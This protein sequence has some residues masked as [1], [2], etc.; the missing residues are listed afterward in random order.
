MNT[1]RHWKTEEDQILLKLIENQESGSTWQQLADKLKEKGITKTWDQCKRRYLNH[2]A[3]D[4]D[5]RKFNKEEQ[6]KLL[7]LYKYHGRSWSLISTFFEKRTDNL[8]K[9]SFFGIIRRCLRF[10]NKASNSNLD[11]SVVNACRPRIMFDFLE[12]TIDT[13]KNGSI[14]VFEV[15]E[16]FNL[17][18]GVLNYNEVD[19]EM[20]SKARI[21][22][23]NFIALKEDFRKNPKKI[24]RIRKTRLSYGKRKIMEKRQKSKGEVDS[25]IISNEVVNSPFDSFINDLLSIYTRLDSYSM[26]NTRR[27]HIDEISFLDEFISLTISI[28]LKILSSS[29]IKEKGLFVALKNLFISCNFFIHNLSLQ[30]INKSPF[31]FRSLIPVIKSTKEACSQLRALRNRNHKKNTAKIQEKSNSIN[32][33]RLSPLPNHESQIKEN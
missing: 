3:K 25:F 8:I 32:T 31:E 17:N 29:Y 33:V 22:L 20:A 21:C 16:Y 15:M 12:L 27:I 9:N 7:D 18:I 5:K 19:P 30:T 10:M 26:M 2:L 24:G 23:N 1:F 11:P 4:I 14:N 6:I 13:E 28:R